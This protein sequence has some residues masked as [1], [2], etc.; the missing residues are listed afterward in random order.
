MRMS[1]DISD[2][3][4]A[5]CAAF[6]GYPCRQ[7]GERGGGAPCGGAAPLTEGSTI[8]WLPHPPSAEGDDVRYFH[9]L[10]AALVAL[11][12]L[13]VVTGSASAT[14]IETSSLTIRAKWESRLNLNATGVACDVQVEG[15]LHETRITKVSGTLIGQIERAEVTGACTGGTMWI[16]N[17]IERPTNTLPWHIRYDSFAGTLPV[18]TAVKIQIIRF[19]AIIRDN[20]GDECLYGS[21]AARPAFAQFTINTIDEISNLRPLASSIPRVGLGVGLCNETTTWENIAD[22]TVAG[23]TTRIKVRLI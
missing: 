11:L 15:R 22:V 23:A 13:A 1:R 7:A 9:P 14:R 8:N 3:L 19:A 18:I 12:T 17:G 21:T 2:L 16:L 20:I 10:L 4:T 5:G 6:P